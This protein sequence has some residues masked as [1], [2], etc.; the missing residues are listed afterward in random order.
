MYATT[1]E[2]VRA[3]AEQVLATLKQENKLPDVGNEGKYRYLVL[4]DLNKVPETLQ[5]DA[6]LLDVKDYENHKNILRYNKVIITEISLVDLAD[7]AVGR[8]GSSVTCAISRALLQGVEVLMLENAPQHRVYAGQGST[9]F[10][11]VLEGHVNT[12]QTFGVKLV[13]SNSAILVAPGDP[14][15]GKAARRELTEVRLVTE[16]MAVK[17]AG[18]V[19]ELVVSPK[20]ILTPA[21]MDVLKEAHVKLIRR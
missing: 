9:M 20:T 15:E 2:L 10:Y 19:R 8:P 6:V 7:T 17:L 18:E 21:A 12:L 14:N 5:R 13:Q 4:G 16:E 1:E 11:R 3:V